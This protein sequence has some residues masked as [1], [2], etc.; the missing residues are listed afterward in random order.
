MCD[1]WRVCAQIVLE[2]KLHYFRNWCLLQNIFPSSKDTHTWPAENPFSCHSP[3]TSPPPTVKTS[4]S[5]THLF[6]SIYLYQPT[7]L[8]FPSHCQICIVQHN[9]TTCSWYIFI[10]LLTH[11]CTLLF[12]IA[13]C[14][15]F[16]F[17]NFSFFDLKHSFDDFLLCQSETYIVDFF[18]RIRLEGWFF[19]VLTSGM[20]VYSCMYPG[21]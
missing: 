16:Y 5:L 8:Y 13:L 20:L 9:F 10:S 17:F 3:G 21:D 11:F 19:A 14:F 15:L 6:P 1:V 2:F 12:W 4:P 7:S 18:P